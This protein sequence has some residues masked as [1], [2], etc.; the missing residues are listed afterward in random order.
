MNTNRNQRV[1]LL[2]GYD[3]EMETIKQI[4]EGRDDCMVI[5]KQLRWDNAHLSAYKDELPQHTYNI[6]YGIELQEDISPPENYH[7]IDH[8]NDWDDKPSVLEQ[9]AQIIDMQLNRYQ[10]LVAA[11]DK[12]YIPAMQQLSATEEEIADIRKRDRAAQGVTEQEEKLAEQSLTQHLCKYGELYVLK[13]QTSR[14][15]PICDRLFPY[16]QL[17]IYTDDEWMY[18]GKGK[19]QLVKFFSNEIVPR[20]VFYG[21]GKCGYIGSVSHAFSKAEIEIIVKQIINEYGNI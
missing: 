1:F 7:R 15:S 4:L 16:Q 3:L 14:F 19:E 12:G 9:V 5:D 18:Y 11:N 21:G 13:S 17:L 2:G 8:H 10:K 20:R 6:I